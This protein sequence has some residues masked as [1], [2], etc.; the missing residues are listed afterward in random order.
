MT[1]G[2]FSHAIDAD[3]KWVENSAR[4]LGRTLA[5]TAEEARWMRL[6]R[7]LVRDF[8]MPLSRAAEISEQAMPLPPDTRSAELARN[9]SRTAA[10]NL[11]LARYHSQ[12]AAALSAALSLVGSR[13]RGRPAA[14]A[15]GQSRSID[16]PRNAENPA[17]AKDPGACR[18]MLARLISADVGF[19]VIGGVAAIAHGSV[20]GT[21]NLDICYDTSRPNVNRLAK[22]LEKWEPYP[23]GIDP[24]MPFT[25][26]RRQLRVTPMMALDTRRGSISLLDEVKGIGNY[27]ECLARSINTY[28]FGARFKILDLGAIIDSMRAAGRAKDLEQIP[29]LEALKRRVLRP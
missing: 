18:W 10:L 7:I 20:R 3:E 27:E 19:V 6:V 12:F 23:R 21:D 16:R 13:K 11:D 24:G 5:Y 29:A 1:R 22:V 15:T 17:P 26:N 2:Q 14:P 25:M 9:D 8:G 4:L 28:A